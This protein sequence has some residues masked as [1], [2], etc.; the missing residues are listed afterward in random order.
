[1]AFVGLTVFSIWS[2]I[3]TK[4][5][6]DAYIKWKIASQFKS[7]G[8]FQET[9]NIMDQIEPVLK[10]NG[11]FM[12]EYGQTLTLNRNYIKG[13]K[14]LEKAANLTSDPYLFNSLGNCYQRVKNYQKAEESYIH[15][16]YLIPHK[17]YPRYLLAKLYEE[18]GEVKK[19]KETAN[20]LLNMKIKVPSAAIVEM[21]AEMIELTKKID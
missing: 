12:F 20:L 2:I 1:M 6:Y 17:F 19:A 13:I 21:R 8:D 9:I 4:E 18:M 10:Y 11:G 14:T 5:K 16:F 7:Y 3:K 15:A